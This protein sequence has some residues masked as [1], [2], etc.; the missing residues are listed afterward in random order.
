MLKQLF[1]AITLVSMKGGYFGR[2]S[3]PEIKCQDCEKFLCGNSL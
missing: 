2:L 3:P 1:F